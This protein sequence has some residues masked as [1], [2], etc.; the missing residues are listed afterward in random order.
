MSTMETGPR[1]PWFKRQSPV[2][3]LPGRV[4]MRKMYYHMVNVEE[5]PEVL[6]LAYSLVERRLDAA[7]AIDDWWVPPSTFSE[8]M[9]SLDRVLGQ[10]AEESA[11]LSRPWQQ[12]TDD[13]TRR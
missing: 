10:F 7:P 8:R 1:V 12:P 4:G 13:L 2:L 11:R 9:E 5:H 3:P 6:P